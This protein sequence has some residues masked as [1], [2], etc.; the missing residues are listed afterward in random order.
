[1][2]NITIVKHELDT[3]DAYLAE[4][5]IKGVT[6]GFYSHTPFEAMQEL[7]RFL[8]AVKNHFNEMQ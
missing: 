3:F 8:K 7:M 1:M 6:Y 2:I 5:K 4:V